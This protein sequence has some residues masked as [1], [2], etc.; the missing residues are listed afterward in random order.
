[1]RQAVP[2]V[3]WR[4]QEALTALGADYMDLTR[5]YWERPISG[6]V[7]TDHAHLTPEANLRLA[8]QVADRIIPVLAG[9]SSDPADSAAPDGSP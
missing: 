5:L 7:F 6:Q 2:L 4:S 8:E 9:A 1:M 3:A